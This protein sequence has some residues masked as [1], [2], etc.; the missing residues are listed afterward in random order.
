MKLV[1]LDQIEQREHHLR[2][3][4]PVEPNA[5]ALLDVVDERV[6]VWR[7]LRRVRGCCASQPP[8]KLVQLLAADLG[9]EHDLCVVH[10]NCL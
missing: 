8:S 5:M 3:I 9:R 10:L 2:L 4:H 7:S 6:Q 1:V